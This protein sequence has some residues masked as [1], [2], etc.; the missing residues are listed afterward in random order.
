MTWSAELRPASR[1]AGFTMMEIMVVMAIMAL[2]A[3]LLLAK[4]PFGSR[5]L[6]TRDTVSALAGGLR[7]AR[8]RAIATDRPVEFSIDTRLKNYHVDEA[9]PVRLPPEYTLGLETASIERKSETEG[10]FRF[11]PDG[12]SSGGHIDV[13]FG[14]KHVRIGVDWL[15]GR[16]SVANAK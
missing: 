8:A 13:V 14:Q 3:G 16:V 11:E 7:E 9:P 2:M 5:S 15:S 6:V 12:S 1:Q 10:A 4:G